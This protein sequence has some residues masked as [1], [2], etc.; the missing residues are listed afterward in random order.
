MG[1][2]LGYLI[3]LLI[4]EVSTLSIE[5][6]RKRTLLKALNKVIWVQND[7]FG[8]HYIEGPARQEDQCPVSGGYEDVS[9]KGGC[10]FIS[11]EFVGNGDDLE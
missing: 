5:E 3:N 4:D 2:L 1:L 7:L 11:T 8:M 10:T 9:G 6:T